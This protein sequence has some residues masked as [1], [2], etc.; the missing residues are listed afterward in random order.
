MITRAK[1]E[2]KQ[3]YVGKRADASINH[4]ADIINLNSNIRKNIK[5]NP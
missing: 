1:K 3:G 2:S 4:A 5:Y